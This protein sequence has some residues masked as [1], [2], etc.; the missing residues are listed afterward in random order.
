MR[1]KLKSSLQ[2]LLVIAMIMITIVVVTVTVTVTDDSGSGCDSDSAEADPGK[3]WVVRSNPL[4]GKKKHSNTCDF[5]GKNI[6]ERNK[7]PV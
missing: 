4:N 1:R 2:R 6:S 7:M 3:V 5:S